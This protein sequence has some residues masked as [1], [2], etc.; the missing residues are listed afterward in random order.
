[1]PVVYLV[2]DGNLMD[3]FSGVPEDSQKIEDFIQKGFVALEPLQVD[4]Q[5]EGEGEVVP[6][7]S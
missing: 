4:K 1:M 7:G 5:N 6:R 3:T 2:R